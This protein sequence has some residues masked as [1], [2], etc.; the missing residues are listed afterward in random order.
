MTCCWC[1]A[2]SDAP[3]RSSCCRTSGRWRTRHGSRIRGC[4]RGCGCHHKNTLC[5][6]LRLNQCVLGC[7]I[8]HNHWRNRGCSGNR[9][10]RRHIA[11][12][13]YGCCS[14]E[15]DIKARPM[16]NHDCRIRGSRR[17]STC[18]S[19]GISRRWCMTG[20]SSGRWCL[21][22]KTQPLTGHG[23]RHPVVENGPCRDNYCGIGRSR[24][25]RWRGSR[26]RSTRR[27][28]GGSFKSH[29][30]QC[31]CRSHCRIDCIAILHHHCRIRGR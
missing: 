9:G 26:S 16:W 27:S 29:T 13:L 28:G 14:R 25:G 3:G 2:R 24:C 19:G 17:R 21:A 8:R 6:R 15:Y 30:I 1:D 10:C 22:H 23:G 7:S 4:P 11:Q 12:P 5:G 18:G 31:R 20:C